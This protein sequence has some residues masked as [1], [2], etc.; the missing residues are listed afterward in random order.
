MSRFQLKT[1]SE[2]S[3]PFWRILYQLYC[4]KKILCSGCIESWLQ[5]RLLEIL[6]AN[7]D[8]NAVFVLGWPTSVFVYISVEEGEGF[9]V[10]MNILNNG[11]FGMAAALGGTMK[12][13]IQRAVSEGEGLF[14]FVRQEQLNVDV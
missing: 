2:V 14:F 12:K 13:L 4:L 1:Y 6:P 7:F 8:I 10:A 11:R 9:K 5:F 3:G